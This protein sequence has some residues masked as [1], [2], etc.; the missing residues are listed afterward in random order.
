VWDVL[1]GI[2]ARAWNWVRDREGSAYFW[3]FGWLFC[4]WHLGWTEFSVLGSVLVL[5]AVFMVSS[6]GYYVS[7]SVLVASDSDGVLSPIPT[8]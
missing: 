7:P 3:C 2:S 4:I 5:V 8:Q 6:M 1:H